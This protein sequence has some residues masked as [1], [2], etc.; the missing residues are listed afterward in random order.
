[1][2][3]LHQKI[4][5]LRCKAN[6]ANEFVKKYFNI[7]KSTEPTICI[8]LPLSEDINVNEK[9][10]Y[11]HIYKDELY[12]KP[13]GLS[14]FSKIRHRLNTFF[15]TSLCSWPSGKIYISSS[16]LIKMNLYDITPSLVHEFT[17]Y[18]Q[19]GSMLALQRQFSES[20]I[21]RLASAY[22]IEGFAV[23]A[24]REYKK[25]NLSTQKKIKEVVVKALTAIS[26]FLASQV[27]LV[28][29]L[30]SNLFSILPK[31]IK[32]KIAEMV[33][34]NPRLSILFSWPYKEG[35]KF[36]K[37]LV[38]RFGSE[39]AFTIVGACPPENLVEIVDI[40]LYVKNRKTEIETV[41]FLTASGLKEKLQTKKPSEKT[42]D[43]Y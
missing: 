9:M 28:G 7:K 16:S 1:M 6:E 15:M 30:A 42:E 24:E 38:E 40:D 29:Y 8:G 2:K 33:E 25:Q 14:K 39:D 34:K 31:K 23:L 37:N 22:A 4:E 32:V 41:Q 11:R 13:S 27:L 36:A 20:S 35:Y 17:H 21:E 43:L 19:R 10:H 12:Y 3:I 26:L 18:H 5:T